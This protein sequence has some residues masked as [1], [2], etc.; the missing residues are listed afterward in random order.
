MLRIG[1][2]KGVEAEHAPPAAS[3]TTEPTGGDEREQQRRRQ[4]CTE[5]AVHANGA[6][7]D[8]AQ[9]APARFG[10]T[11]RSPPN[12]AIAMTNRNPTHHFEHEDR[13]GKIPGLRREV[14]HPTPRPPK[15]R[16]PPSP[17]GKAGG[18]D[19]SGERNDQRHRDDD[20]EH[21][22]GAGP[23]QQCLIISMRNVA[24]I[25]RRLRVGR[26]PRKASSSRYAT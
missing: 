15:R 23:P 12:H 13:G 11:P 25:S 20:A 19:L 9:V 2:F 4:L 17:V 24:S 5:G 7:Q 8:R 1:T 22:V 16:P 3:P 21:D 6:G 26:S 10:T 18:L 14:R